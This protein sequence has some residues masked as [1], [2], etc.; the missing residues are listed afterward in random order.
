MSAARVDLRLAG[1][2]AGSWLA[3]LAGLYLSARTGAVVAG[4]AAVL[5]GLTGWASRHRWRWVAVGVLLGVV[6]GAASTAVQ[7]GLRD[8]P[9]LPELARVHA[10]VHM[11]LTVSDDPRPV[12]RAG[13]GPAAYVVPASA[14]AVAVTG[15]PPTRV[16]VGVLVLATDPAWRA[17]LPG[18][19]V[20]A[21]GRLEPAQGGDLDAAVLSVSG[22]P[23]EVG[24][25]PWSQRA[26]GA[27]R[28][29][30]RHACAGLPAEPGGLL[31]GL[32][33]GDTSGLTPAVADDFRA[34]GMTHLVA[35]SGA[36][37]S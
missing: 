5:A 28:A 35:V 19:A 8:A 15:Q 12:R 37:V 18:T 26:A 14:S 31:P 21:T 23:D 33:D 34:T 27:L 6:C 22:P 7:V 16:S 17:L 36:N 4:T 11:R 9:P 32:V 30:L 13:R 2:A 29:G 10:T 25:A 3:A 20:G 24:A 1:T